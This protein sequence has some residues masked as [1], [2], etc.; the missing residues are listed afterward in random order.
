MK[1]IAYACSYEQ[2]QNSA[3]IQIAQQTA[4]IKNFCKCHNIILDEIFTEIGTDDDIKP[5]LLNIMSSFYKTADKIII[6]NFEVLSK[7]KDFQNWVKDEFERMKIEIICLETPEE[8]TFFAEKTLSYLTKDIKKIPSDSNI[9]KKSIEI[10]QDKDIDLRELENIILQDIGLSS[11]ILKLVNS[12]YYGFP[13]MISTI[14]RAIN[15]LGLT[16][17]KGVILSAGFINNYTQNHFFDYNQFQIQSLKCA[18]LAK[19]IAN[20]LS[21]S[22]TEEIYIGALL[23]DIGKLIFA[24]FDKENYS[25]I[26]KLKNTKNEDFLKKEEEIFGLNHCELANMVA[27]SWN[28]PE[29]ISDIITYHH[30]PKLSLNH[31]KE[32]AVVNFAEIILESNENLNIDKNFSDLLEILEISG[33]NIIRFRETFNADMKYK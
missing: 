15:I 7:N 8:K 3:S 31:S 20:E 4:Q 24:Q 10:M 23:H 18:Q 9:I 6:S 5:V 26:Y 14:H 33:D 32:C 13:K 28:F 12:T 29:I 21:F 2:N 19:K 16:T 1:T 25:K 30:N 11:R 17:I 27:Y 22:N